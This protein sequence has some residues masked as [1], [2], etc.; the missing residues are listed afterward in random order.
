MRRPKP[1]L[2]AILMILV[3][4]PSLTA[5]VGDCE[6][7]PMVTIRPPE[8]ESGK[9]LLE[10]ER[11]CRDLIANL[12]S[13]QFQVNAKEVEGDIFQGR[14]KLLTLNGSDSLSVC[15]Y[16][17]ETAM[18]KDTSF[19]SKDGLVYNNGKQASKIQWVSEPRFFKSENMILLYVG[20]NPDLIDTL[21]SLVGLPFA[22]IQYK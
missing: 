16:E 15:L 2:S 7:Q 11:A 9:V 10:E 1:L 14:R 4:A 22:G 17:N 21:K 18:E 20:T 12:E 6:P 8:T 5:C 13:R 3:L 19:V